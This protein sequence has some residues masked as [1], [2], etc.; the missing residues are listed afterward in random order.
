MIQFHRG[1]H[2]GLAIILL[3]GPSVLGRPVNIGARTISERSLDFGDVRL[4]ARVEEGVA[5]PSSGK[6]RGRDEE[7]PEAAKRRRGSQDSSHSGRTSPSGP[8]AAAAIE[9][10]GQID[11]LMAKLAKKQLAEQQQLAKQ[12]K[13][14]LAKQW[15]RLAK[16]RKRQLAEQHRQLAKQQLAEQRQRQLA[17]QQGQLAEPAHQSL[18]PLHSP[19]A[20]PHSPTALHS[21]TPLHSPTTAPHSHPPTPPPTPP[22]PTPPSGLQTPPRSPH[23]FSEPL[24]PLFNDERL[25]R[26]GT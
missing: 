7:S 16:Q 13:R 20:L 26:L 2:V 21:P 12:R 1:F 15:K 11:L 17:E 9:T 24:Q 3:G 25:G 8:T 6:K 5:G 4:Y 22:P 23:P 19:T 14:Q 10:R 18:P